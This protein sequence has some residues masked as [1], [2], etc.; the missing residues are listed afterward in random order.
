MFRS[1]HDDNIEQ[2]ETDKLVER[3]SKVVVVVRLVIILLSVVATVAGD[4]MY[5]RSG[6]M[7][8]LPASPLIVGVDIL[9]GCVHTVF[10]S[11]RSICLVHGPSLLSTQWR[12]YKFWAPRREFAVGPPSR[13]APRCMNYRI[14]S[15]QACKNT[16]SVF[17]TWRIFNTWQTVKNNVLLMS[18]SNCQ[19]N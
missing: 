17:L 13:T 19:L 10:L 12:N 3:N 6:L 2:T 1:L 18:N 16:Y 4:K 15:H 11:I 9:C 8:S 5:P 7:Y 14:C